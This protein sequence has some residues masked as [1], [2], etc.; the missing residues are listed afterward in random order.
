WN[1][2]RGDAPRCTGSSRSWV[3]PDGIAN[4]AKGVNERQRGSGIDF[5]PEPRDENLDGTRVVFV[6]ALPDPF[7]ELGPRKR[8]TRFLHQYLQH[9]EFAGR[10]RNRSS[11]ARHAAMPDVHVKVSDFQ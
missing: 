10:E 2:A 4:A 9:V 1:R 5:L 6:I 3:S 11:P 8:P 7:A